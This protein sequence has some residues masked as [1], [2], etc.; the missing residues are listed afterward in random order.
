MSD[1]SDIARSLRIQAGVC[2]EMG[3]P[4]YGGF[5]TRMADDLEAGGPACELAA[6]WTGRDVRALFRDAVPI[7][8]ANA[9][10]H[11][12][13][14]GGAPDLSA[15]WPRPDGPVDA[16]AAWAAAREAIGAHLPVLLAFTGHEPQTNEVRRSAVLL[17][18][19][20]TIAAETGLP[21]RCFEVGASAGLN[22]SWDRFHYRLGDAVWGDPASPVHVPADWTGALPPLDAR[23]EV[24][25]RAA[26]DRRPTD[27]NDPAQ[28]RRLLANVW[29]D[30]FHRIERSGRA[31]ELALAQGVSV[32]EADAAAWARERVA[33]QSGA[34]TVLYHSIFWQ[35][36]DDA[37][38]QALSDAI[39]ALG[40]RARADAPFAWL[41]M[42]PPMENLAV[43]ELRLTLWPGGEDRQLAEVS[44]HG[45]WVRWGAAG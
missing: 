8:L 25:E 29:P 42:E 7:R 35:Y 26:C 5:M 1:F 18:G 24:V 28:R 6:G 44:P 2:E 9:F 31:I 32:D 45:Q 16:E 43:T 23:I 38:R 33:L 19:F 39:A 12:A 21:L 4:F 37:T 30:Q 10:N 17:A 13:M 41:R 11:L 40:A 34:A 14:G 36:P 20:L 15:A 3:S 27:L 22:V